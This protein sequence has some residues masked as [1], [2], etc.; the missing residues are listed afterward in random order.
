MFHRYVPANDEEIGNNEEASKDA[1]QEDPKEKDKSTK[2]N[3]NKEEPA[4]YVGQLHYRDPYE[5]DTDQSVGSEDESMNA[6]ERYMKKKF[7]KMTEEEFINFTQFMANENDLDDDDD[8]NDEMENIVDSTHK[9]AKEMMNATMLMTWK[10]TMTR[11]AT[12][13]QMRPNQVMMV[14]I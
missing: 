11:I 4:K 9:E 14:S 10:D 1:E 13:Y 2:G 7:N 8:L 5:T 6:N 12:A 3:S